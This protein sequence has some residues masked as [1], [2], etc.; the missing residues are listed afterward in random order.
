LSRR[1]TLAAAGATSVG[2]AIL[3]A[4]GGGDDGGGTGS[5]DKSGL[6]TQSVNT[7]KEARKGGTLKWFQENE[8]NHLDIH[9]GLAPLNRI[10]Q[11]TNS[12]LVNEQAGIIDPPSFNEVVPD[13]AESWEWSPDRL[14]LTMKI[15]QGVKW[16][17]KPPINGRALD[18]QDITNAWDRF[19]RQGQGRASLANVA[20]PNAPVLGVTAV[21]ART[22]TWKLKEPLVY[23]LSQLTPSQTG[24]YWIV[25]KETDNG[26][27]NRRDMIGT[28]PYV[29]TNYTPSV[30]M[31]FEKNPEYWDIKTGPHFDKIEFPFIL[32]YS[33]AI[34][35]LKAGNIYTYNNRVRQEE[36]TSLKRENPDLQ[37]Y[38][39]QP[40]SFS[41]GNTIQFGVLPTETNKAFKDERVRQALSMAI[42]REAYIDVFRNVSTFQSEGLP[43]R[44]YWTTTLGEGKG[45]RL[46]PHD[47]E[48]GPNAKYYMHDV[49]E[50]KKLLA[51]AGYANGIDILTSFISGTQLGP[52]FQRT[53]EVRQDM[54]REVGV[55]PQT[56][57]IDYTTEY[58]PKYLT[59]A[60]KFDGLVYRSGVASGNNA[61]IWL[62]W[63]FKSGGG[64]GWIGFD[65]A[66][67]GDGSGDPEVDALILKARAEVD[68]EKRRAL[69]YDLQRYLAKAQYAISEPGVA[70]SFELAWPVLANYR[71]INGDRRT[72][73]FSWW[74]DDTKPPIKRA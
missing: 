6:V 27:D 26:Y 13:L 9:I 29:L 18:M 25:P 38:L 1:R 22:I 30:S 64:D 37:L 50:A 65:K 74:L 59:S 58:L 10:N 70:D 73:A 46:D 43:V 60:G 24:N 57:L 34:A 42:D 45:W 71:A 33:Q 63:R 55:R 67:K 53:V 36:V 44:S 48:F 41:A 11:L 17:N 21:D 8:P 40:E 32:E 28:G 52:D 3:A 14:S 19:A 49:A 15:R 39:V 62:D 2:A 5:A 23:F 68:T 72:P 61:V 20:N 12:A 16:H 47:K 54:L 51:A 66:G 56:N 69:V 4:C 7:S 35:Q 31:S